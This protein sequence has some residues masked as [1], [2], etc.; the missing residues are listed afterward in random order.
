MEQF[1][2]SLSTKILLPFF[3]THLFFN[4]GCSSWALK[5]KCENT[6]WFEYSQNIAFQGKYLEED[7]FVKDCKGVDRINAT[8]IDQGFKLGREKMCGYDEIYKRALQGQPVFFKFCDGLEPSLMKKRFAEGLIIFCTQEKGYSHG[9]SGQVYQKVCNARQEVD[10]LPGYFQGRKEYLTQ[11]IVDKKEFEMNQS[12]LLE[13]LEIS[14]NNVSRAYASIP[15]FLQCNVVNVYNQA[16]KKVESINSCS[17]PGYIV[18]QRTSLFESLST[19]RSQTHSARKTLI[20]T[21]DKILWAQ[22]ELSV[23]PIIPSKITE[24]PNR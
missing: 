22:H 24:V 9:K 15:N 21:R 4:L 11:F 5:E 19:A 6:N 8:Q 17:E 20:E 10:F 1:K 18:R 14:E 12:H 16:T 7:A 13:G 2:I 23:L 3:L